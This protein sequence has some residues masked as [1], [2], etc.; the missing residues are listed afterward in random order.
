MTSDHRQH[1]RTPV[2]LVV[3]Y[4]GA[5]DFLGDYTENLS[6]GGTFIHTGRELG[7]GSELQ[8]VLS[9]PGLLQPIAVEAVVRWRRDGDDPGIGVEFVPSAGREKLAL[10]ADRIEQRD[11]KTVQRVVDVLVVEDNHHVSELVRNGL[12]VSGRRGM[13]DV[14]FN[15]ATAED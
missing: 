14:A 8:L 1:V 11:P 5:D 6:R 4:T 13:T 12:E 10:I 3:D 15:V 7:I 9:F 2:A